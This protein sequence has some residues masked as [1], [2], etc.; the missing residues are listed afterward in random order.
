LFAL[1]AK[2]TALKCQQDMSRLALAKRAKALLRFE[3][4]PIMAWSTET[5]KYEIHDK[6]N[7]K[8]FRPRGARAPEFLDKELLIIIQSA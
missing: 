3:G 2:L 1:R 7:D 6:W 5:E 8:V 4:E